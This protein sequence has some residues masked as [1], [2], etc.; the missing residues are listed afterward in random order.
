MKILY[1]SDSCTVVAVLLTH[2]LVICTCRTNRE[3]CP[4]LLPLFCK[5]G[6]PA[7]MS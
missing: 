4:Y 5:M 2:R 3:V 6:F 1:F 7:T